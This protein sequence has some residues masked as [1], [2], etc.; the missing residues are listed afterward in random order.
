MLAAL[1]GCAGAATTPC[2]RQRRGSGRPVGPGLQVGPPRSGQRLWP[3][4]VGQGQGERLP[5]S[6][7]TGPSQ[8]RTRGEA[9]EAADAWGAQLVF[10]GQQHPSH[11]RLCPPRTL[12]RAVRV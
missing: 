6:T 9:K 7:A 1:P 11:L 10:L 4:R 3:E 8:A 5:S 12:L 2:H